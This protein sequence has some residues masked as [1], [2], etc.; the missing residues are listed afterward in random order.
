MPALPIRIALVVPAFE[1]G[2]VETFLLR[3]GRQLLARGHAVT[4]VAT[5]ERG[6]WWG[7]LAGSGLAAECIPRAESLTRWGHALRVGRRLGAFDLV[8][9]NHAWIAQ[10]RLRRLPDRVVAVPVVHND[11]PEVYRVACTNAAAWNVAVA[12]APRLREETLRRAP[13][14]PVVVIPHGVDLPSPGEA[15]GRTG[16]GTPLR[17]IFVG[18]I[19]D[20]QKGVFLLPEILAALR[21][22]GVAAELTVVGDGADR[23]E[24]ERRVSARGLA[25]Q[26]TFTGQLGNPEVYARLLRHDV[27]LAPSHYEGLGIGLIE[28]QACGCP[29]VATRLEGVTDQVVVE[30]ETG[31]LAP[32]GDVAAFAD[33]LAELG[34][35]PARWRSFSAA[36][37]ERARRHFSLATMTDAYL[38]LYD[39]ARQGAYPLPR[40]RRRGL[41]RLL[42]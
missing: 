16:P 28:A 4:V 27:L 33:R 9:L 41:A 22:R 38:A 42:P 8:L 23:A 32:R 39:G 35:D 3:L 24:L 12:V 29:V 37:M 11:H 19:H 13:G 21:E 15:Q 14:R 30:G 6:A 1:A 20:E 5:N 10:K 31:F 7:E 40:P 25:D 26:V 34:G 2:G 36:G 17:L 18:R